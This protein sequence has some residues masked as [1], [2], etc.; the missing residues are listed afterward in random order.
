M[1][2]VGDTYG[3]EGQ[4]AS[5]RLLISED[6]PTDFCVVHHY[7]SGQYVADPTD[8]SG[9]VL[10]ATVVAPLCLADKEWLNLLCVS[11]LVKLI[12]IFQR[13]GGALIR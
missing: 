3:R 9:G 10:V 7:L 2:R 12:V 4:L 1:G 8:I 11:R 6:E 5:G 13:R